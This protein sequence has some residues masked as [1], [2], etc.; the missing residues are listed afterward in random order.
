L[1][2]PVKRSVGYFN[3]NGIQNYLFDWVITVPESSVRIA[4]DFLKEK[5]NISDY[6]GAIGLAGIQS[7]FLNFLIKKKR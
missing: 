3:D 1:N 4:A 5:I 7:G 2:I 6:Y